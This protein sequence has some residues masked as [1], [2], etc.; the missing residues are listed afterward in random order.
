MNRR[1]FSIL[2]LAI[3][4]KSLV[5]GG[6]FL[7]NKN[8]RLRPPRS[9][10]NFEKLC[11]RCGQCLQVCPYHAI[12]L[13]DFGLDLGTA[14]I[15]PKVRG[16]YL[17]D[18]FPCVLACPSGALNDESLEKSDANMG[19]AVILNFKNCLRYSGEILNQAH[20]KSLKIPKNEREK[21]VVDEISKSIDKNCDLCAKICPIGENAINLSASKDGK[22]LPQIKD[23]C[24]GCGVC[25]E[26]CPVKIIEIIPHKNFNE[27]YKD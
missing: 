23:G 24:V 12:S 5:F 27:I 18:L 15:D 6:D 13:V 7:D 17:C 10:K 22:I 11:V 9:D 4:G 14:Y 20:L 2:S 3:F 26:V 21:A 1:E 25:A 16:C 19:V 8:I